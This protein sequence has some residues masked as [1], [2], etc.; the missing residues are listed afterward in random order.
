MSVGVAAVAAVVVA[1]GAIVAIVVAFAG[2]G[3]DHFG[4]GSPTTVSAALTKHGL[5]ICSPGEPG[6]GSVQGGTGTGGCLSNRSS[7]PFRP[8]AAAMA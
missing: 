2:V 8:A 3:R 4:G 5:V 6:R 1:F 7:L